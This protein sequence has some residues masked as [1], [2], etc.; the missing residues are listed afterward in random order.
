MA[1]VREILSQRK[2]APDLLHQMFQ[3]FMDRS[4]R[5][6]HPEG[7]LIINTVSEF[8]KSDQ[9]IKAALDDMEEEFNKTLK[10]TIL[11]G[12]KEKTITDT[13]KA[14][15]IAA[16]LKCALCGVLILDRK[17]NNIQGIKKIT[18]HA[19]QSISR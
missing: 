14:A 15:D 19:I 16:F 13:M 10:K 7:C 8:G 18:Y 2:A 11:V 6:A 3:F 5:G 9:D 1:T 17:G 4:D 12:Q